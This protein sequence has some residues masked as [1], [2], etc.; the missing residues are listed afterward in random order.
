MPPQRR[1]TMAQR[2]RQGLIGYWPLD[3]ASGVRQSIIGG[4]ANDLTD[5]N[6]VTGGTGPSVNMPLASDF[7]LGSAEYLSL[8]TRN[9][10][11]PKEAFTICCW[12]N[13]E[14]QPADLRTFVAKDSGSAPG[15]S[16]LLCSNGANPGVVVF[17]LWRE[18][19][20]VILNSLASTVTL[21]TGT[22]FFVCARYE[23]PRS[24]LRV[25]TSTTTRVADATGVPAMAG[26]ADLNIGR[27]HAGATRYMDGKIAGVG[28]WNRK[29]K[30]SE[31]DWLY[32]NGLGRD[33]R[34]G[35]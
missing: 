33:L 31:V 5:N 6:T 10:L 18:D 35:A 4:A 28:Y 22:W 32:N 34:R 21:T 11:Q 9:D 3:E 16:F 1:M 19:G 29:L 25:N 23:V 13:M 17:S 12:V 15:R 30:D 20:T 8:A 7:E 2:L 14:S 26:T 27:D 24:T